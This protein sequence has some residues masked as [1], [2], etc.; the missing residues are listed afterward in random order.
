MK[1]FFT[2]YAL[3]TIFALLCSKA[4]ALD[5]NSI[6]GG[7]NYNV[8]VKSFAE[9]KFSTV[10]KQQFD[11]SCGSAALA[12]LLTFHYDDEVNEQSVFLDMFEHGDQ[13]KIKE[14][15][16]S[17]LDMKNYL[18]RRGYR[19]DGFKM[20]L[21]QLHEASSPAITIIDAD[22]Y[23]HFIII[24]GLTEQRVLVGD[25]AVGVNIIPR[26]KFEEIW[27]DRI[28]FL[29]HAENG[30]QAK[31]FQSQKEWLTR[32]APM[33]NAIDRSSLSEYHVL[34]RGQALGPLDF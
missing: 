29:I 32:L 3:L 15:G 1:F 28:L 9:M 7:G 25:P 14:L 16:F 22:G 6:A 17:L 5:L 33:G 4:S 21:D 24:K 18:E 31:N 20:E 13:E 34:M 8:S 23:L 12:S 30:I 19:S 26:D 11:F 27:G 10:Y 2:K